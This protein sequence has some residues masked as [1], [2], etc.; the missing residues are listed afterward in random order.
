MENILKFYLPIYLVLYIGI[1]FVIPTYRTWKATG[2]NPITFG[3][4]DN[5]H[6]YIG[7]VMKLLIGLLFGAVLFYAFGGK[8]YPY[9]L[10]VWY[11][12]HK[13]I[14]IIGIVLIHI[15]LIWIV[16][17]QIQMHNSW[18]IGIDEENKTELVT[19]GI[20]RISRNP[21][22]LGMIISTVGLFLIIPNAL[23]FFLTLTTYFIIQIQIRLEEEFL[24]K[25][26]GA[27]YF[28]YRSKTKRLL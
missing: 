14:I 15:S 8:F 28:D 1:A 21:I 17:A 13:I 6:N 11:L 19:T 2:I 18:R 4:T 7:F 23:T 10:P 12:Q 20:F 24:Q 26:H 3:K 22:F 16:V 27:I 9:L 25:V 5:A